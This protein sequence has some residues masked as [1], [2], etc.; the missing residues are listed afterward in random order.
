MAIYDGAMS[1][2]KEREARDM[3]DSIFNLN[4]LA[5]QYGTD[6]GDV[7]YEAH[8]YA[9]IY[10]KFLTPLRHRTD[11]SILEIGCNDPRFPGASLKM[12]AEYF[13]YN[14][15][16][17]YGVD[18][19]PPNYNEFKPNITLLMADQSRPDQL[20]PLGN[21]YGPF[22]FVLDDGAHTFECHINSFFSLFS[23]V[24]SGGYYFIEDCHAFDGHKT[25]DFFKAL[26]PTAFGA[27]K[28]EMY[29]DN[30]LIVITKC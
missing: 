27:N 29:N 16:K 3:K 18:I 1:Y 19:N 7:H 13:E 4:F 9:P 28:V 5:N 22:D 26:K 15:T 11:V 25:V 6:K 12:W 30:K 17:I 21:T 20:R 8:S 24:K 2:R 10:D 14:Q 23:Y